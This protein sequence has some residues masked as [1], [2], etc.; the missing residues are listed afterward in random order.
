VWPDAGFEIKDSNKTNVTL[1]YGKLG[2]G[3]GV[4]TT[5]EYFTRVKMNNATNST[6]YELHSI[7][8]F[9][10]VDT[11]GWKTDGSSKL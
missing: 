8:Y 4:K 11:T 3:T 1:S 6:Y 2:P 9:E 7:C 10:N 5:F